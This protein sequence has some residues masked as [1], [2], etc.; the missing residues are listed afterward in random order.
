MNG[1]LKFLGKFG[2]GAA[3][4]VGTVLGVG[5]IGAAVAGGNKQ[6]GDCVATMLSQPEGAVTMIGVVLLLFGVGR[7]A[8]WIAGK[9]TP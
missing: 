8:G 5:G 2:K 1:V 3:S 4:I 9:A 7:K 6:I